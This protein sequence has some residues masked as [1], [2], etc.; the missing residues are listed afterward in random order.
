MSVPFILRDFQPTDAGAVDALV[1][2]AFHQYRDAYS[3]WPAFSS[4]L[5]QMVQNAQHS[6]I[7]VAERDG[8]VVGAVAYVG[9]SQPKPSFYPAEWPMLR[10]LVADPSARALG[11]GRALS[12]EAVRRAVRDEAPLIA[13]HTSPIMK[14]ALPLYERM[15]FRLERDIAPIFGV[16][17]ALY[18]KPLGA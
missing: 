7:I 9:A 17:Y 16:P 4:R 12:E 5:G 18:V 14:V 3:D 15:G 10:M 6:E 13:L 11:I 2:S 1:L 8:V